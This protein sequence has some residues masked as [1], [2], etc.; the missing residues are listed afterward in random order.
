[1]TMVSTMPERERLEEVKLSMLARGLRM[2]P[3]AKEALV[4]TRDEPLSIHEYPTTGGL[5]LELDQQVYINAPFDEWYCSEAT[6]LLD[7]RDSRFVLTESGA[8]EV[9]VLRVLPL[10][11]Y[12]VATDSSG[13][14]VT[15]VA[16]S[17][18]DRVRLSPLAGCAYTCDFCDFHQ[19]PYHLFDRAQLI[20]A[21]DLAI[22][23]DALPVRHMLISGG[24]PRKAL[25]EEFI[26][27]VG[28]VVE[29]AVSRGVETD[30][31]MSPTVDGTDILD[32]FVRRGATGFSLNLEL[33]SSGAALEHLGRK[34]R[35]TRDHFAPFLT[36]AVE[37]LGANGAVRSL[38]IP[39]LE[40]EEATLEGIDWLASFGCWPVLSPFRPAPGT[41]VARV[42][43][44]SREQLRDLLVE[45]R[46]IVQA[47]GVGLGPACPPCQHNTLGFPWDVPTRSAAA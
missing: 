41:P 8:P 20:E 39:G 43:P 32:E 11:G 17:H 30:I 45:S 44:P 9:P 38:I 40:P 24:S 47:R 1:M 27:V 28:D 34:F 42:L 46:R 36:R 19:Q 12:L 25:Y 37:L 5:T 22:V 10:P 26:R 4:S 7:H 23:D 3:A 2:A 33:H 35:V 18:T 21:F 16:M 15:Q 14:P 31:M 29:H 13:R 6:V